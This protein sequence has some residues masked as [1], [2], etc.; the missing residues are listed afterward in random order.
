MVPTA[1]H[2]A[3]GLGQDVD[4]ILDGGATPL[5]LESTVIGFDGD[6]P[7]LLVLGGSQGAREI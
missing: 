5:G 1:A 7:V 4:L 6:R 3:A 2:A